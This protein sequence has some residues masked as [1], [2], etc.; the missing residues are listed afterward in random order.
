MHPVR[1][2]RSATY[3]TAILVCCAAA[4]AQQST[5]QMGNVLNA[6]PGTGT[7]G[8]DAVIATSNVEIDLQQQD[9]APTQG[10]AVVTLLNLSGQVYRQITTK[11]AHLLFK[12]V[13]P[14]EYTIQ[15]VSPV[16][17]KT[18]KTLEA[19]N[20]S[21]V[22]VTIVL[23][24]AAGIDVATAVS[25]SALKPKVQKDIAKAMNALRANRPDEA[26]DHLASA[27]RQVPNH[28]EVIYLQ[29]V[30]DSQL[31]DWEK[32]K[33]EW[34][35]TIA[36]NPA[37]VRALLSLAEAAVQDKQGSQ[38]IEYARRAAEVDSASWR[39]HALLAEGYT[40]QNLPKDT[41][42]EAERAMELG[43]GQETG[44][45]PVLAQALALNGEKKRATELLQA[46][47]AKHPGDSG[48]KKQLETLSAPETA[49]T[50]NLRPM[51]AEEI[52]AAATSEVVLATMG[53]NEW[54]PADVDASIPPVEAGTACPLE[55][56][57]QKAS[58]RMEELIKNVDRFTA[59]ESVT[60]ESINGKGF[61]SAPESAKYDY[62]VSIDATQANRLAFNEFREK[63]TSTPGYPESVMTDG[64]PGMVLVFHPY[65]AKNYAMKCEGLSKWNGQLAWQVHFQQR[66]DQPNVLRSYRTGMEGQSYPVALKGRAWI[67]V[68]SSQII[69]METDLMA[70]LPQI[71][72]ALDHISVE[73]A[74]VYFHQG[75]VEMW[76]PQHAEVF[77]EWRGRRVHSRHSFTQYLLFSV[78]DKQKIS[79]PKLQ[80]AGPD[81][82]ESEKPPQS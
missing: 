39:A 77:Y 73:Y 59:V 67:G 76:L 70:P 35:H 81:S 19:P 15:V 1:F 58:G 41:I 18:S 82:P 53:R 56:V 29:G 52:H 55:E 11:E 54:M 4:A 3:L 48:V 27:S 57:L 49:A 34:L 50:N 7:T 26:R 10:V 24:P 23:Q 25:L 30:Y 80:E 75:E 16:Y 33:A 61:G 42:R 2:Y 13:A 68:E 79:A 14:T 74:P 36:L 28:P 17:A 32:A 6:R 66:K 40:L 78:D 65:Y 31:K 51:T 21:S 63:K 38:A 69:R 37:H 22:R 47:V 8:F 72:L 62:L 44:I 64:L 5:S 12:D 71:R 20:N 46:Y 45:E 43:R 9:G 60:H